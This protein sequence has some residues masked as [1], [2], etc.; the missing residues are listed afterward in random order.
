MSKDIKPLLVSWPYEDDQGVT[1]RRVIGQD[2]RPKIQLRLEMGLLQMEMTGRPDG[3]RPYGSESLLD[4]CE[5]AFESHEYSDEEFSLDKA[6]CAALHHESMLYYYRRICCLQIGEFEQAESD[7][8][9]NLRI[10]DVLEK[11]AEDR[12]DWEMSERY[13]AYVIAHRTQARAMR[14]LKQRGRIPALRHVEEGEGEIRK[15]LEKH[16]R[17]HLDGG[18]LEF[19][20]LKQLRDEIQS[21]NSLTERDLLE[22]QLR[23][24]VN[25]E[26]FEEA[27]KLR[28]RIERL[29]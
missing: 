8:E 2:D 29:G 7:A 26:H 4:H 21:E 1:A 14:T 10:M 6:D 11:H 9:H 3:A 25:R 18:S 12:Q 22:I 23:E 28:D 5:D 24:A 20:L 15:V 27:A 19:E 17:L 13:R 16:G